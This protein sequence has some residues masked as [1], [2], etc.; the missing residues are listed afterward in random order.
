MTAAVMAA[1]AL[2]VG[3]WLFVAYHLSSRIAVVEAQAAFVNARYRDAQVT[4]ATVQAKLLLASI[5]I[6]DAL[7]DSTNESRIEHRAQL[8]AT[9]RN[10]IQR[11]E[12]YG[13]VVEGRGE[14]E[15][16]DLLR[17]QIEQLRSAAVALLGHAYDGTHGDARARL[18]ALMSKREA[19][20][21]VSDEV[22]A[23]AGAA[24]TQQLAATARIHD[25]IRRQVWL[26]LGLGVAVS[27]AI[28]VLTSGYAQRL[29]R[30][31]E[32]QRAREAET[33]QRLQHLSTALLDAQQDERRRI[34]RELHDDVGQLLSAVKVELTIANQRSHAGG[35]VSLEEAQTIAETALHAVRDLSHVLH[36]SALDDLG[37]VAA[38]ESYAADQARRFGCAVDLLCEGLD[39]GRFAPAVETAVFRI[40]QEAMTNV[41]RHAGASTCQVRLQCSRGHL[42]VTIAD[43]GVGFAPAA[44]TR[45][46]AARRGLGLLSMRERAAQ[47]G[48]TLTIESAP[49]LGT[50]VVVDLLLGGLA[51]P[52]MEGYPLPHATGTMAPTM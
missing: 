30:R 17:Q 22:Q 1:F 4:V 35:T 12:Q 5:Q 44:S 16:V 9:Y 19:A 11:I 49:D 31:L 41:V 7:L 3:L 40:V 25:G 42:R 28:A 14:R 20:L 50:T 29:Q 33:I 37:L 10:A 24:L 46:P 52:V 27:L 2:I 32:A 6:R 51:P 47:F 43:D 15:R 36:P 26:S 39:E 34:A 38:L 13:P 48:G 21:R 23:L 45:V 8:E 18:A